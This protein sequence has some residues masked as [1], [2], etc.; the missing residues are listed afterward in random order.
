LK[1]FRPEPEERCLTT[2]VDAG[3]L[4]ERALARIRDAAQSG[5][6]ARSR[7]LAYLLFRWRELADE[8]GVEVLAWT[9]AKME[10]DSMIAIFA[11]AFTSHSWSHSLGMAGLGDRVAKRN[12]RAN[13]DSLDKILDKTTLRS[14]VEELAAK[15]APDTTALPFD[16][17]YLHGRLTKKVG[18]IN[19][20][21]RQQEGSLRRLAPRSNSLLDQA[22]CR[23]SGRSKIGLIC[24]PAWLDEKTFRLCQRQM[25]A[26]VF[27]SKT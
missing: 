26:S 27:A 5:E 25:A 1:G 4:R 12:I 6:L 8:E 14:R 7:R 17:S 22:N 9:T 21:R 19:L 16:S 15:N 13:V 20:V 24:L 23:P 18:M 2:E 11:R 3:V 10:D